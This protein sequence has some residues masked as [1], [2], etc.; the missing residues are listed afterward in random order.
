MAKTHELATAF[1]R[2]TQSAPPV[3]VRA[4]SINAF[5]ALF[6]VQDLTDQEHRSIEK[7]LV[8]GYEP[9]QF[10]EEGVDLDAVEI[11]KITKELKAIKRQELVL[12][13]ERVSKAREIFKKYKKR[14]FREW[15]DFTFG[16]FKTGYNYLSFYDLYSSIPENLQKVLKSMPARAVYMLASKKVPIEQKIDIIQS[17]H[18]KKTN[19]LVHFIREALSTDVSSIQSNSDRLIASLEKTASL[20]CSNQINQVQKK[21]LIDLVRRLEKFIQVVS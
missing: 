21:R 3:A 1:L 16:S 13:G 12:V 20:L 17:H 10:S 4:G 6:S 19:D 9:G 5:N 15:M 7:I 14:S 11:K 8:E 18:D 2:K